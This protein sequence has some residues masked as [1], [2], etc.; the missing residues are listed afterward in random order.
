MRLCVEYRKLNDFTMKD[1]TPLPRIDEL[2]DSLYG[3]H[4]FSTLDMYKGYHQDRVKERDIHKTAFRTH[5]GLFEYC[6][7]PFGLCNGP[8]AFHAMMNRVLAPYL[9][10][11]CVVSVDD[12]LIYNQKADEHLEHIRLVLRELQRHYLHINLSKY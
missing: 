6:V 5:Y 3:T 11:F 9:S 4:Y 10:K 2:P 7:L 8:A 12:V 1:R